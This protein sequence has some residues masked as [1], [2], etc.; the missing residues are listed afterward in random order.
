ML[1]RDRGRT[2]SNINTTFNRKLL[3]QTHDL[4]R[5]HFPQTKMIHTI[6]WTFKSGVW[7]WEWHGP[8]GFTW[9]GRADDAY[10]AR[11][12]GWMAWLKHKGIKI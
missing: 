4:V 10:E 2:M 1:D 11:S 7:D 12:L 6:G 3:T 8:D 9:T 5:K